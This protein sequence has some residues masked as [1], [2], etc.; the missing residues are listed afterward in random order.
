MN[1]LPTSRLALALRE[2]ARGSYGTEAAVELLIGH[3]TWLRRHDF[4]NRLV[5]YGNTTGGSAVTSAWIS[6]DNV[7]S[8]VVRARCAGSEERILR[9]AAELAGVDSGVPLVELLAQLDDTNADLVL[10]AIAHVL[11]RGGRR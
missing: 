1:T 6:W 7:P 9:L 10:D 3:G 4:L 2:Q 11:T 8:F 5:E